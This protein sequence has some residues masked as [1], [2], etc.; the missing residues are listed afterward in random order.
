M[1]H[2]SE[3]AWDGSKHVPLPIR[4]PDPAVIIWDVVCTDRGQHPLRGIATVYD[5]RATALGDLLA[6][7][8]GAAGSVNSS[9]TRAGRGRSRTE[10]HAFLA[11]S[12]D[13]AGGTPVF[14]CKTCRRSVPLS[15]ARLG[16]WV[17]KG[18]QG[19]GGF[20]VAVV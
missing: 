6:V 5:R 14:R 13:K 16:A 11:A 4:L 1:S 10:R 8:V 15:H 12:P 2:W 17:R 18:Q 9:Q 19:N 3:W 20:A 7:V